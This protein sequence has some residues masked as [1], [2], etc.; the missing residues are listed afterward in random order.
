LALTLVFALTVRA[1][2]T[3]VSVRIEPALQVVPLG[4][5]FSINIVADI[6]PPIVGWGLDL[7]EDTPG[8]VSQVGLPSINMPWVAANAPDGDSLAAMAFPFS[9]VNG[10]VFGSSIL[11]AT[12]SFHADA[13]GQTYLTPS[14]TSGDLTEGFPLDPFGFAGANYTPGLVIVTPE[15]T[16]GLMGLG[17]VILGVRRRRR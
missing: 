7:S 4:S 12:L 17:C 15:P 11:L 13:I 3:D 6:I 5:N 14:A 9:P 16:F 8:I 1:D 2:P 10:S